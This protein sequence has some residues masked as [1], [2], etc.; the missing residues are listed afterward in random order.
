MH[1][2]NDSGSGKAATVL[3][4]AVIGLGSNL[5]DRCGYLSRARALIAGHAGS[6]V[7][8]SSVKETE[9]WGFDAPPFLNQIVVVRT[10]LG[11]FELLDTLQQIEK[12]LGRTEKSAVIEGRP[13]YH[14]RTIDLDILYYGERVIRSERLV[15]PHPHIM[16]RRFIL[17]QLAE[18]GIPAV[19]EQPTTQTTK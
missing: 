9:S 12:R 17:E 1:S 15:V 5:G 18:L 19:A 6:V 14:N 8:A 7:C 11:P 13:V 2:E 4:R 10:A 16:E 3:E